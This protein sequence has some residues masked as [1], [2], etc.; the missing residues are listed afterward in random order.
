MIA[1]TINNSTSE[2]P[3]ERRRRNLSFIPIIMT[4]PAP[5]ACS[6]LSGL[7][8]LVNLPQL[9]PQRRQ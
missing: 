6:L 4:P 2:N 8:H 5:A 1:I 7:R 3:P 9:P